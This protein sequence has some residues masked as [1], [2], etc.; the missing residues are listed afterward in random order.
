MPK[1]AYDF[2]GWVT[3]NDVLCSDGAVIKK[4]AFKGNHGAKVPLMWNHSKDDPTNVLGHV[5]LHN[6]EQ[7][8]YGYGVF[9][10]TDKASH[11]KK[12]L[13]HGD[14]NG[15]SIGARVR[16][17]SG[18]EVLH[19]DIYEVSLVTAAANPGAL[20]EQVISHSDNGDEVV[21]DKIEF[22]PGLLIHSYDDVIHDK[23]EDII[24]MADEEKTI[25]Q[26]M[27][28]LNDEQTEAVEALIANILVDLEN[29]N[30]DD[31]GDET[32]KHNLFN[33]TQDTIETIDHSAIL[34]DMFAASK[35]E[36]G[37][38]KDILIEHG[39]TNMEILF[40]EAKNLDVEPQIY[41]DTQT[42]AD[43]IVAAINKSPMS[44]VRTTYADFTA[45]EARARGYIKGN[46]KVEQVFSVAKRETTPT[47]IY[48]KQK[49]D[50]QDVI[51]IN[52][53]GLDIVR[54]LG[55]EMRFMLIEEMARAALVG[56]G[57]PALAGGV[58]NPDKIPEENI[59]PI[60]TD[61]DLYTI[62]VGFN[63]A[64]TFTDTFIRNFPKYKGSGNP[65]LY[66]DPVLLA[67]IKLLKKGDGSY[68][69]GD[70]PSNAAIATRLGINKIVP[71]TFMTGKGALLVNLRD[72]NFGSSKGGE[73]TTFEDF[74]IDYNQH[75]YLIETY[76]SGALT[77][78]ESA[79]HFRDTTNP[80]TGEEEEGGE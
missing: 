30:E 53:N 80:D 4:D 41:R 59:R 28:T 66:I 50:R 19:G 5:I 26:V 46:M 22:Y 51:D 12:M 21:T 16:K 24:E 54:F 38:F 62:K 7:G 48:K 56:D 72:Y 69:F 76:L 43:E 1:V 79:I 13:S 44:R 32:V 39:I 35:K 27:E 47:M 49:L 40:P 36:Q 25:G 61:D 34:S 18:N 31:K 29:E 64:S 74:D 78:L 63:G 60:L 77:K 10:D 9:N 8:L 37:K 70:I 23:E 71:T 45:D 68:M 14:I 65:T 15:M 2:A 11:A 17:R 33:G 73:I 6:K 3:K 52:A 55:K 42:A 20:I 75:K 67:D 57:R 58:P